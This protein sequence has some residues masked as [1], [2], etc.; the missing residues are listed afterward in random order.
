MS[1]IGELFGFPGESNETPFDPA[2]LDNALDSILAT[3]PIA[4][5]PDGY[6]SPARPPAPISDG[7]TGAAGGGYQPVA[8]VAPETPPASPPP[9]AWPAGPSSEVPPPAPPPA[10]PVAPAA[11]AAPTT[12]APPAA[13]P[14]DPFAGTAFAGMTAL[15]AQELSLLRQS[16]RD[17]ERAAAV[18]RAYIGGPSDPSPFGAPPAPSAAVPAAP[19]AAPE[20]LPE[21]IDPRSFEASIWHAQQEQ[22][23]QLEAVRAQMETQNQQTERQLELAAAQAAV[24]S[25]TARY[26]NALSPEEIAWVCQT[27]GYQKLPEAFGSANPQLTKEQAMG[28]ALE[29]QLRSTDTLFNKIISAPPP[30][31]ATAP[32]APPPMPPGVPVVQPGQTPEADARKRYLTAV[33]SA[34][35]PSGEAPVRQPIGHRP[36][37]KLDERSR[38]QLVQEMTS[39]GAMGELMGPG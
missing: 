39:G 36:D 26:G 7:E 28:Q 6:V 25:F 21:D 20:A 18:R 4:G 22:A 3:R 11:P 16:L 29:F 24:Q 32:A 30:A 10:P 12:P 5:A 23:R 2:N 17:P 1:S 27:A 8:P 19:P 37:G 9:F 34:A 13:V 14:P 35:S 15:E 31:P 38:M 33:S